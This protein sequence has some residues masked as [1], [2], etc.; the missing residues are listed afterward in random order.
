MHTPAISGW[1]VITAPGSYHSPGQLSQPRAVITAQ[2]SYHS[3]VQL[4]QPSAVIT[5]QGSYHSPGQ[6]SQPRA[7]ITAQGSYH[8]P[9][10]SS[11]PSAVITAQGSYHSPRAVTTT[12]STGK[13]RTPRWETIA[14]PC[15]PAAAPAHAASTRTRV[16]PGSSFQESRIRLRES[17]GVVLITFRARHCISGL[18]DPAPKPH[19]SGFSAE[20]I[21]PSPARIRCPARLRGAGAGRAVAATCIA[22]ESCGAAAR[23]TRAGPRAIAAA[24]RAAGGPADVRQ[25]VRKNWRHPQNPSSSASRRQVKTKTAED[26]VF[27][28][29]LRSAAFCVQEPAFCVQMT[30]PCSQLSI[31]SNGPSRR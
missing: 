24:R 17:T 18:E 3:P 16:Q 14:M 11:Q 29:V 5:A 9:G 1:A 2:C 19:S 30:C 21:I 26:S 13:A 7:V 20:Q 6:L 15:T 28:C 8:S 31:R 25:R 22:R 23:A 10:Q 12:Y 4:S 27:S